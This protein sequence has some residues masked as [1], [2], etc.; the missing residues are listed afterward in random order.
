MQFFKQRSDKVDNYIN[1]V[2]YKLTPPINVEMHYIMDQ[3]LF[4]TRET[5]MHHASLSVHLMI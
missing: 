2:P 1:Q 3:P 5:W 4:Q